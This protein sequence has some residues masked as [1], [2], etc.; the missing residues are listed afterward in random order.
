[1]NKINPYSS[2]PM[3]CEPLPTNPQ[4]PKNSRT[5]SG[6]ERRTISTRSPTVTPPNPD[7]RIA[8]ATRNGGRP[9]GP[10]P[11]AMPPMTGPTAPEPRTTHSGPPPLRPHR[12]AHGGLRPKPIAQRAPREAHRDGHDRQPEEDRVG[13]PIGHP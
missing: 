9:L 11:I 5:R 13:V 6:G 4:S 8:P 12:V 1:M 7:P 2:V 3:T 10:R